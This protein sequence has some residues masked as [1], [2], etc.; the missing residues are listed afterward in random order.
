MKQGKPQVIFPGDW[1]VYIINRESHWEKRLG[2]V[3]AITEDGCLNVAYGHE[4]W[5]PQEA[6]EVFYT[7]TIELKRVIKKYPRFAVLPIPGKVEDED[8]EA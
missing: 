2:R 5:N 3:M 4:R 6:K 8:F 1:I 7:E